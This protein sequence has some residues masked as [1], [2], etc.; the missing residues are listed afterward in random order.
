MNAVLAQVLDRV[1]SELQAL[2][3]V[4]DGDV[5]PVV[6]RKLPAVEEGIDPAK[7]ITVYRMDH[8]GG[9]KWLAFPSSGR[10][11]GTV[12]VKYPVGV[13]LITP[14]KH[15]RLSGLDDNAL[16]REQIARHF[17]R[18]SPFTGIAEVQDVEVEDDVFLD[19]GA[20]NKNWDYQT[21]GLM[22]ATVEPGGEI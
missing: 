10:P 16:V 9:W 19:R 5:L 2:A 21:V 11:K 1:V 6:K 8:G 20:M 12:R 13:T 15:D 4:H 3:L 17:A 22:V 18:S 14:G 7:Q